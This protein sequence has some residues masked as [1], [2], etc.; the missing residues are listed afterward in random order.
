MAGPNFNTSLAATVRDISGANNHGVITGAVSFGAGPLGQYLQC[1]G[2]DSNYLRMAN[3]A[4]SVTDRLSCGAWVR[5]DANQSQGTVL[6]GGFYLGVEL[7]GPSAYA[8]VGGTNYSK[9][10][11]NI[12]TLGRWHRIVSV[13]DGAALRLYLDGR[14]VTALTGIAGG[15]LSTNANTWIGRH[16]LSNYSFI[17]GIAHAFVLNRSMTPGEVARDFTTGAQRP[18]FITRYLEHYQINTAMQ[19][20]VL[21]VTGSTPGVSGSGRIDVNPQLGAL[22]ISGAAPE[23]QRSGVM[24]FGVSATPLTVSGVTSALF[25]SGEIATAPVTGAISV[26]GKSSRTIVGVPLGSINEPSIA[27]DVITSRLRLNVYPGRDNS[28]EIRL[29]EEGNTQDLSFVSRMALT[30]GDVT[31]DSDVMPEVFDWSTEPLKLVLRLGKC[32]LP[33]GVYLHSRLVVYSPDNPDGI[34]WSD[35]VPIRV[36]EAE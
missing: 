22:E 9:R 27:G 2:N 20:G 15:N 8:N 13:F 12:M 11:T 36:E 24:E 10:I 19:P 29:T 30:I 21:A 25:F 28:A 23:L 26:V 5:V 18:E 4:L 16:N 35:N 17:G 1:S 7:L 6:Y 32:N 34:L 14:E 31:I 33:A 3:A